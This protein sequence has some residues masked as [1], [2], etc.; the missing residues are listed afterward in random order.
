M[1]KR[2]INIKKNTIKQGELEEKAWS[3]QMEHSL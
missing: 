3:L 1:K 2:K